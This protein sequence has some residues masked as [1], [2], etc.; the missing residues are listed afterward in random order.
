MPLEVECYK[1][2]HLKALTCGI[3][4]RSGH[5]RA[6]IYRWQKISLKSTHFT[7]LIDQMAVSFDSICKC[8]YIIKFLHCYNLYLQNVDES[9]YYEE[10]LD[11]QKEKQREL[12]T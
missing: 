1:V 2:P 8:R 5:W 12:T 4:H 9:Q 11:K 7:L 10:V 3:K 6:N